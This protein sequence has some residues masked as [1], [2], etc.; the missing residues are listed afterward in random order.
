MAA[1]ILKAYTGLWKLFLAAF[2][3]Y[4]L[5]ALY[6][7]LSYQSSV[8]DL[9]LYDQ[10]LWLISRGEAPVPS[11]LGRHILG[12]HAALVFYP[13]SLFYLLYPTP[14]WLL[15]L[16]AL[17]LAAAIFPLAAITEKAGC[18]RESRNAICLTWLLHPVLFNVNMFDF[19]TEILSLPFSF[20]AVWAAAAGRFLFFLACL[21]IIA[22]TKDV[23]SLEVVF[24][25]LW[26][27][28]FKK[29]RRYGAAAFVLGTLTFFLSTAWIIP[30]YG[31]GAFP[32]GFERYTALGRSFSEVALNT[33]SSPERLLSLIEPK[34]TL[35][36]AAALLLPAA[37]ALHVRALDPLIPAVPFLVLNLFS[38]EG[39]QRNIRLHYSAPIIPFLILC[40]VSAVSTNRH[41]LKKFKSAALWVSGVF[42]IFMLRGLIIHGVTYP[43]AW[44]RSP[45]QMEA[46][47]RA[48]EL[49]G[50]GDKPKAKSVLGTNELMT[51]LVYRKEAAL[52]K[53]DTG[54]AQIER[55]DFVFF[56]EGEREW[57][58][59]GE[60]LKWL[61]GYLE[62]NPRYKLLLS[63]AGVRLYGRR[64]GGR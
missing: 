53:N 46:I 39:L 16:Q 63:E 30:Q 14:L 18:S 49:I 25:G 36:Y 21:L 56:A 55:Y 34:S 12:D 42:L 54:P 61:A 47:E 57:P 17:A 11:F 27:F 64:E 3:V 4:F 2:A 51:H 32:A 7:H 41:H 5:C 44:Y 33:L 24:L 40:A 26:L 29:N 38:S 20:A 60:K 1:T 23:M 22:C 31:S 37:W 35:I 19:H 48:I 52:I 9:G 8:Y 28:L 13:L 43:H 59:D 6:R 62:N 50:A 10:T 58:A 15:A 45:A